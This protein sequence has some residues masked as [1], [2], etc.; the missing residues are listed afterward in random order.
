MVERATQYGATVMAQQPVKSIRLDDYGAE[1]H[2]AQARYRCRKLIIAAGPWAG[3][4]LASIGIELPLTVTQE[5]YAFFQ[6]RTPDRFQP[7]CLPIFIHY[8][9]PAG[10]STVDYY[11]FPM[12]DETGVKVGEHHA[13]PSV[14]ADTRTFEADDARL[15]RLRSYVRTVLPDTEGSVLHATTCLYTNTPDQHFIIDR[16]PRYPHVCVAAG[17]SGHG[18]KFAILVGRMLA[19]LAASGTTRYPIELF[20]LARFQ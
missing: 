8:G 17:F 6:P 3:P 15:Q 1:V 2:T 12:L 18:F 20:A 4:L 10:K 14:T 19:D 13:G 9:Y 5:Q 7:D 16:L 11:G